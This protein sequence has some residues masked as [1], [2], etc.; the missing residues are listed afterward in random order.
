[1]SKQIAWRKQVQAA[2]GLSFSLWVKARGASACG[3]RARQLCLGAFNSHLLFPQPAREETQ[4]L[5]V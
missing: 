3:A 4:P 5:T 1:M 2:G